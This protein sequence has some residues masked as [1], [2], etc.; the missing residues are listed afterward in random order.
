VSVSRKR[1]LASASAAVFAAGCALGVP[2]G[3]ARAPAAPAAPAASASAGTAAVTTLAGSVAPVAVDGRGVGV[4][5]SSKRKT[6]EVWLAG[7]QQAAQWFVDAVS[8]P[9]SPAYH[10]FLRPSSYTRRFGP[11]VA[12]LRAVRSFLSSEDFT[13]VHASVNDDYVSATAPVSTINRAFSVQMRRYEVPSAT[14]NATTIQSNDRGLT[15]PA[16]IGTDILAV[17]GLNTSRPH[18]DDALADTDSRTKVRDCSNYWAQKTQV[19]TPAFH[20]LTR[21]ADVVCGYS[22][23]QIRAAYGLTPDD[24]GTGKTIALI[25]VGAPDDMSR[26]LTDYAKANGLPTPRPGQYR[27]EAVGG[28]RGDQCLNEALE[29]GALDSE[30]AYA[31]APRADQLLV[32]G[33]DD[34]KSDA[35][36]QFDAE[37]AP[38]TGHGRPSVAIES[39]SYGLSYSIGEHSVPA[40]QVKVEHAIALRAAAEGVSVLD[41]SG[42]VPGLDPPDS[43][44]DMT[45][46]GGTTLG[47]GSDNQRLFETGWSTDF[48]QRTGQSGVWHDGGAELSS[49]GGVSDIYGEPN[50]QKGVVPS[51]MSRNDKG[52]AGR[53]VPDIAADGDPASGMLFGAIVIRKNGKPTPYSTFRQAGTSTSTPLVAGIVADAEQGTR[54]N[55]G[56]LNPLLYSMSGSNA[57]HDVLPVSSSDPQVDRAFYTPGDTEIDKK[58]APGFLVGINDVQDPGRSKQVT[59]PGYDTITGLGT[60]N[61]SAFL[62]GLRSSKRHASRRRGR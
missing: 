4:V 54:P 43:D 12:Q 25:E 1:A 13:R 50:Y 26:A 48:G 34:A 23:K 58:F 45:A 27:E 42:D 20:G 41:A 16:S 21:A 9:G 6:I 5:P 2:A 53:V 15:V 62:A 14:A 22:A 19:I 40:S 51:T 10:R 61:G 38:L 11:S 37:L 30:A 8:T 46:V 49:G 29:E 31:M 36:A 28:K 60:P 56:F 33:C 57:F 3:I 59:A 39:I 24:T 17:T 52:H 7:H 47:I 44:P 55:L 35:Q 32:N 18:T